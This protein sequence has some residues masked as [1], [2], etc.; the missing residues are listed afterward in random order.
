[1]SLIAVR[2]DRSS[3]VPLFFQISEEIR[4]LIEDG[5]LEPGTFLAGENE[6][7]A[8]W[9]VS[10]PTVRRAMD[11]LVQ[12]GLVQRRRGLGTM[13]VRNEIRRSSRLSSLYDDLIHL[14][15]KPTTTVIS[16]T[17]LRATGDIARDMQVDEGA[18]VLTLRR[19]RF[20]D[21]TGLALLHNYIPFDL[22]AGL[23]AQ[24]F[25]RDGLYSM[26]RKRGCF[27]THAVQSVGARIAMRQE[28]HHLGISEGSPVLTAERVTRDATGR[29]VDL[30]RHVYDA[31]HYLFEMNFSTD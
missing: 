1:M 26:L 16:M 20:V 12:A 23:T 22:V 21:G 5:S 25:Q 30:G 7:A 17:R 4:R 8:Q 24:D 31:S 14:D 18:E 2:P 6:L 11:E 3:P 28:A 9:D 27:P 10:R 19:V 13:V 29:V 15:R